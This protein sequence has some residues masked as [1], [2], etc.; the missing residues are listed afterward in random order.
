MDVKTN[1]LQ[2]HDKQTKLTIS[3]EHCGQILAEKAMSNAN[4]KNCNRKLRR[5]YLVFKEK[6][7]QR[8]F[9]PVIHRIRQHFHRYRVDAQKVADEHN[10]LNALRKWRTC[11]LTRLMDFS[12]AIIHY[13]FTYQTDTWTNFC[14]FFWILNKISG[15]GNVEQLGASEC[16]HDT[17]WQFRN[18]SILNFAGRSVRERA[19]AIQI[20][21]QNISMHDSN[22]QIANKMHNCQKI[23]REVQWG[24]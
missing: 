22:N 6:C 9:R 10:S 17:H 23:I 14:V 19:M 11:L 1:R 24:N 20:E 12:V 18:M 8:S 15:H 3:T 4:N 16:K 5:S 7:F 21:K 2:T 13:L